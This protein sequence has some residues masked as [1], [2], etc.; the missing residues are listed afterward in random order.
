M[1]INKEA[2]TKGS[3]TF[4]FGLDLELPNP[5][6]PKSVEWDSWEMGWENAWL[7][8]MRLKKKNDKVRD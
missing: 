5:F 7:E 4:W 6:E 3:Q 2:Y 8:F 1:T